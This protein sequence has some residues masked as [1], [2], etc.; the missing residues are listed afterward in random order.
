MGKNDTTTLLL[1]AGGAFLVFELMKNKAAAAPAPTT[2]P[3]QNIGT[4]ANQAYTA[5]YG[6]Y[7]QIS[8]IF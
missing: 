7:R 5:G 3:I 6:L 4:Y 8:N 2:G 1:L